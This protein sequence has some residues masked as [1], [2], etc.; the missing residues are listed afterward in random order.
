[1]N[2]QKIKDAAVDYKNVAKVY[3]DN[4]YFLISS[5][6]IDYLS[7]T[8]SFKGISVPFNASKLFGN[9]V[10]LYVDNDLN[11]SFEINGVK[12]NLGAKKGVSALKEL[13]KQLFKYEM[14]VNHEL[15]KRP[16]GRNIKVDRSDFKAPEAAGTFFP[17]LYNGVK[18]IDGIRSDAIL[19]GERPPIINK[20]SFE[21]F[22]KQP[23]FDESKYEFYN[24]DFVSFYYKKSIPLKDLTGKEV[25]EDGSNYHKL[26]KDDFHRIIYYP[27]RSMGLRA[28]SSELEFLNDI[29]DKY[30]VVFE[31][32]PFF[33]RREGG[34]DVLVKYYK[35]K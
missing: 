21:I 17:Q 19:Q 27:E 35:V 25:T 30:I 2:L 18:Y 10:S 34:E 14:Q 28:R 5:R 12:F 29:K 7:K 31:D 1:M 11:A 33:L 32:E 23:T 26:N 9:D 22:K 16:E 8:P 6:V 3:S 20:E 4:I 15:L 13:I 24:N